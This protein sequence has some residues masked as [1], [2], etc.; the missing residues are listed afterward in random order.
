MRAGRFLGA[1]KFAEQRAAQN[2]V[3]Q[4]A[5]AGTAHAGD[6]GERAQR[7]PRVNVAQIV[8]LRAEHFEPAAVFRR[9]QAL[10][11]DGNRQFAAQILRRERIRVLQNFRQRAR[12]HEFAAVNARAGAE[13]N[14]VIRIADR[15]GVVLDHEHGVAEVAQALE[16]GQQAVV[17]ALVQADARLVQDVEHADQARAD[18]GG[19]PDALR[20]A[21]AQRAALAVEREIAEADVFQKTEPG[22]DFLDDLMRDFLLEF[23]ELEAGKKFVRLFHRQRANVHD[24]QAGNL[25]FRS[26]ECGVAEFRWRGSDDSAFCNSAFRTRKRHRQNF[27]L[28]PPA[29][30]HV[31]KLRAHVGLDAVADEFAFA[32][33]EQPLQVRQHALERAAD[34]VLAARA[35]EIKIHRRLR[36]NRAA[37]LF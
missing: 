25:Q 19:Q 11:R 10:F 16:R 9:R 30:A 29:L 36:P 21:A 2:V 15:V 3:H 27:R 24:G 5:F 26:A 14:D 32:V 18:L 12:R 13:V 6:A 35:P 7:N 20:L 17:V 8:F 34:G 37:G 22:A 23:R 31:A 28:E 1:V 4:R 33:G